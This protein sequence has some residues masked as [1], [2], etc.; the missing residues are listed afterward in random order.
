MP[1]LPDLTVYVE[2]LER[3]VR[4]RRLERIRISSPFLLRTVEPPPEAL[5]GRTVEAVERIGK[6]IVFSLSDELFLLLHLMVAGRLHWRQAGASLR[7]RSPLL[8]LDF[9]AGTL[10]LTEA[11]TKRRASLHL[12]RGKDALTA[13]D[14]GGLEPL[15]TDRSSFVEALRRE[16]HTL[17]RA[18]TDPRILK[19]IGNAYSDEILHHARLSPAALTQRLTESDLVRLYE[20]VRSVLSQWIDRLRIETG[21]GF[22]KNVTA[23]RKEMAVHGRYRQPCPACGESVQRIVYAQ[24]EANYCPNCQTGGRLLAD[25]ALS[26]LLR[27]DW[28]K[29]VEE[30]ERRKESGRSL[31]SKPEDP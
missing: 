26:R 29:T 17:K 31:A 27:Q 19:G 28:P 30:L 4:G 13:F 7:G 5:N 18:L 3:T 10:L 25:R 23:F 9:Q 22:P 24:N 12:V 1:E 15:E 21:G 20:A 14:P 6:R 11:G 16:N 8:A 2:A